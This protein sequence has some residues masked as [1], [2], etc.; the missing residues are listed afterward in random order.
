MNRVA[1]PYCREPVVEVRLSE[2]E[3]SRLEKLLS[4]GSTGMARA[5]LCALGLRE[6]S[7]TAWIEH[8]ESCVGSWPVGSEDREV[9]GVIDKAFGGTERPTHFTD[10]EHCRECA[11][12]DATLLA[13]PREQLR[14]R[15]LGTPGW[16]PVTFTSAQGI[17]Y[18]MPSLARFALARGGSEHGWYGDQLAWHLSYHGRANRL[19]EAC[20]SEQRAAVLSLL[21]HMVTS[22]SETITSNCCEREYREALEVWRSET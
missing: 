19:Y 6:A 10:F 12:H 13:R 16:D 18:L 15:D 3:V 21:E 20:S 17:A 4:D 14:R 22:R 2:S 11:E 5:E 7:A 8:F 9:L 1:C